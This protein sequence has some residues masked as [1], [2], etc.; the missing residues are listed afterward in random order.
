M[1]EIELQRAIEMIESERRKQSS[2][3]EHCKREDKAHLRLRV[4]MRY[5]ARESINRNHD[6]EEESFRDS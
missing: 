1:V 2:L 5:R 4:R 6:S 3:V